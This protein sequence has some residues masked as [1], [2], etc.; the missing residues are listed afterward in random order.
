SGGIL[1]GSDVVQ[2]IMRGANAVE[3]YTAFIYFGIGAVNKLL[4]E[5]MQE[6]EQ[7]GYQS[8]EEARGALY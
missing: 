5:T 3:I 4:N 2:R 6:L 7:L 8:I 1:T